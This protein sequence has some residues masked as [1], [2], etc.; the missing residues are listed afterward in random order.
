VQVLIRAEQGIGGSDDVEAHY[1]KATIHG[2]QKGRYLVIVL[3][4]FVG[5]AEV[6]RQLIRDFVVF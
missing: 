3:V 6:S 2:F 4:D 5:N 1:L